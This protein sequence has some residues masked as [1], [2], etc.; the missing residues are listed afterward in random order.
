MA[1]TRAAP[2]GRNEATARAGEIWY[3]T[4][5]VAAADPDPGSYRRVAGWAWGAISGEPGA[6]PGFLR[7]D[8]FRR[9]R[10]TAHPHARDTPP[11]GEPLPV[12]FASTRKSQGD[13]DNC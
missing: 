7:P 9:A 6:V 4:A 1:L 2:P 10:A 13:L 3:W 11:A 5:A 8:S 12:K